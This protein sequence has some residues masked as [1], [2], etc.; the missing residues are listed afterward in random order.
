[1][2]NRFS[3]LF[4]CDAVVFKFRIW[5]SFSSHILIPI[6]FTCCFAVFFQSLSKPVLANET[7]IVTELRSSGIN[8][9]DRTLG[10]SVFFFGG[11]IRLS[12]WVDS[13][14][15]FMDDVSEFFSGVYKSIFSVIPGIEPCNEYGERNS[16]NDSDKG[17][18]FLLLPW[19]VWFIILFPY[20]QLYYYRALLFR[21]R[22]CP[23]G[24]SMHE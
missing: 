12:A 23:F 1:M 24:P 7:K 17:F 19:W 3:K 13:F 21:K 6:Y 4:S 16:S 10:D 14:K 15:T 22:P 18:H 5:K 8:L 20:T 9:V 2:T 11:Q